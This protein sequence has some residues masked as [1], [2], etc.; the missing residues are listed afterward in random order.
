MADLRHVIPIS[1]KDSAATA[2]VQMA[3]EPGLP[4]EFIFCD[5][6]MELPETYAWLSRL[7]QTLGISIV[8][9]GK[10]LEEVIAEQNMLPSQGRR[11][12]TKYGKIFPIRDYL[13][14][15]EAVQYFGIRADEAGRAGL[16]PPPNTQARYPLVELGLTIRHVYR[17]LGDRGIMPPDF[18]WRRLY[19]TV[20]KR[21]PHLKPTVDRLS[22]WDRAAVFAWRSRSNCF[23]CFY[24]RRYEWVGLLEHHPELFARA[25]AIEH[26]YGTGDRRPCNDEFSWIQGLPLPELRR[27]AD[28][29]FAHRVKRVRAGLAD[30]AQGRLFEEEHEPIAAVSCGL[31]CGK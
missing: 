27:R 13:G 9:I 26:D 3:R 6:R 25:E 11:F 7:E 20:L 10:S 22:P 19:E 21:S 18:F 31:Y 24:Q 14:R 23:M 5:V 8:R 12:C 4:Y 28:E 30:L 16:K 17:L 1:G 2:V 15:A 29:I